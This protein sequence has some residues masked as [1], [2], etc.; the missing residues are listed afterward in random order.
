MDFVDGLDVIFRDD[1][2]REGFATLSA[3][4]MLPTRYPDSACM[5]ALGIEEH[6]LGVP[7][8]TGV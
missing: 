3:R 7:Q 4:P 1:A 6:H 5:D 8:L 2:Q